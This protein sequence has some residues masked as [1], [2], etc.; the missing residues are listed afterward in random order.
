M[1]DTYLIAAG[2]TGG[3][4]YPGLALGKTLIE[5]DNNVIFVIKKGSPNIKYLDEQELS[6]QEID[7]VSMPRN[8]NFKKWMNFISKF[9]QSIKQMRELIKLTEPKYCI[10]MGGYISFP[11]VFAAHFMGYK[12]AVH[13]SNSRLGLANK[14]CGK[15]VDIVFLGLPLKCTPKNAVLVGTPI[16]EEFHKNLTQAEKIYWEAQSDFGINLLIFGGSQGARKLNFAAA[17]AAKKLVTA[18]Q[19]RLHIFHITGTRD[20]GE[21][22]QVYGNAKNIEIYPYVEDIYS[23]MKA[24]HIIIARS[25]ASSLAE[26]CALQKPAILVPFPYA[27]DN[28]QYYNAKLFK[29]AGLS[30]LIEE[31]D[32]LEQD[33]FNS[34]KQLLSDPKY[35]DNMRKSYNKLTLPDPLQAAE[36]MCKK[37]ESCQ[38]N[39]K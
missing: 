29:D 15:F 18:T 9:L 10:G 30:M 36:K 6:Y 7:F 39:L 35:L 33:I 1:G 37:L 19:G 27:A 8:L 11:L 28:H 34:V 38:T 21:I 13:D 5:K 20:F 3:H 4:F 31:S 22:K 25:G 17:E 26:I 16:R 12:T 24:S 32:N 2:G 14:I 23:L